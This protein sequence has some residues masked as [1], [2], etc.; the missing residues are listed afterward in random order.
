M[1]NLGR[2]D[3]SRLRQVWWK[4]QQVD[5]L[6]I[7]KLLVKFS[8]QQYSG[9]A[10]LQ[11]CVDDTGC[12]LPT[13]GTG[14]EVASLVDLSRVKDWIGTCRSRHGDVCEK[15]AWLDK[16]EPASGLR[17]IDVV[18]NKVIPAVPGCR[19]FALSY[20]WGESA[21]LPRRAAA[22]K[23][24]IAKLGEEGGL[25]TLDLPQTIQ[26]AITLTERLGERYLWVDALCIVQDDLEDLQRQTAAMDSVLSG[27]ALTIAAAAGDDSNH[28]LPGLRA[29]S[30]RKTRRKIRVTENLSLLGTAE[31]E[32]RRS[33]W[34][35]RGWTFQERV[36]SRRMLFFTQSLVSWKCD[37]DAWSEET[38]LEPEKLEGNFVCLYHTLG[39][40]SATTPRFSVRQLETYINNYTRRTLS[41]GSDILPAFQGIMHRYEA[42]TGERL[43]WGLAYRIVDMGSSLMWESPASAYLA[44][45]E[46]QDLRKLRLNDGTTIHMLYPSW[47]WMRW[48]GSVS[49]LLRFLWNGTGLIESGSVR[50][51]LDFYRLMSDGHVELLAP[52][53]PPIPAGILVDESVG[54]F[55]QPLTRLWKGLTAVDGPVLTKPDNGG[56]VREVIPAQLDS[57][58][59][60]IPVYDTGRLVFRASHAKIKTWLGPHRQSKFMDGLH[61]QLPSRVL[62][63]SDD[64]WHL[65]RIHNFHIPF[66]TKRRLFGRSHTTTRELGDDAASRLLSYVVVGE[67]YNCEQLARSNPGSQFRDPQ[68]PAFLN[69]LIIE[70]VNEEKGIARRIGTAVFP[71]PEWMALDRDWRLIIL[72]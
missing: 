3:S 7:C 59:R 26:D 48:N 49:P 46:R 29:G 52:R 68:T 66:S 41:Y 64:G 54:R 22:L 2:M 31:D 50:P 40:V 42:A 12:G 58:G 33:S 37:L 65:D 32:L 72:E 53:E 4:G 63:A 24:N 27:A 70:W 15:P 39:P 67:N 5:E 61:L 20:V 21:L 1:C 35:T 34:E 55:T 36:L 71:E 56:L 51:E 14:R 44:E 13:S 23:S 43:H 30:G 19:Y 57:T 18:G 28:G 45:T 8:D 10:N 16:L 25:A 62:A 69:V 38:I 11:V 47:S 9:R 6:A 17:V 60:P